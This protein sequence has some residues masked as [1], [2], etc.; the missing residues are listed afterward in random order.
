MNPDTPFLYAAIGLF[1]V[2][3]GCLVLSQILRYKEYLQ[4]STQAV[5]PQEVNLRQ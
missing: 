2:A 5:Q 4:P 1:G 3:G